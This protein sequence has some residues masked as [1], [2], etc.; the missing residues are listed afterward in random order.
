MATRL[1]S[2]EPRVL[3]SDTIGEEWFAVAAR[4][5]AS[6]V[7]SRYD[8]RPVREISLVTLVVARPGPNDG[9]RVRHRAGV[10]QER[11]D[12]CHPAS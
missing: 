1:A 9:S 12:R 7:P 8:E 11:T 6:G 4:I 5:V 3:R 2:D 10:P